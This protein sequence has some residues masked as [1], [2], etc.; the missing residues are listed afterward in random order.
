MGLTDICVMVITGLCEI[1]V[2]VEEFNVMRKF[3]HLVQSYR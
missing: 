3:A 1:F 2:V